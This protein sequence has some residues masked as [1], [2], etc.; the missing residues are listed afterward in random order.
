[1]VRRDAMTTVVAL[2]QHVSDAQTLA[3]C[4]SALAIWSFAKHVLARLVD[5]GPDYIRA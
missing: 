5:R 4:L 3:A 1:M 2:L